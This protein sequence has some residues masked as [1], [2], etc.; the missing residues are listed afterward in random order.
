MSGVFL[1]TLSDFS[2]KPIVNSG[3]WALNFRAPGS[4][5]DSNALFFTA[6]INGEADGL[7][8]EITPAPE[9]S[10]LVLLGL[11]L[12]GLGLLRRKARI[13]RA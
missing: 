3:L 5:F 13:S 9:P 2:G 8:G 12:G 4:G 11:G 6:G 7:F 10:T 1:G